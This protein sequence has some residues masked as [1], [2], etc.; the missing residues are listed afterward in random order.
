VP[1]DAPSE[2]IGPRADA[3]AQDAG[4]SLLDCAPEGRGTL[5]VGLQLAPNVDASDLWI[6]ALCGR[7][8]NAGPSDEMPMRVVRVPRLSA[9]VEL[10][11][12]GEGYYR[13]IASALGTPASSSSVVPLRGSGTAGT[14]VSIATTTVPMLSVQS[15]PVPPSDAGVHAGR[16]AGSSTQDGGGTQQSFAEFD[17]APAGSGSLGRIAVQLRPRD[18]EWVDASFV[19][20]NGCATGLC[21][22]LRV[23]G[24]ELRIEQDGLPKALVAV[25]LQGSGRGTTVGVNETFSTESRL[26][27]TSVLGAGGR[28]RLTVF[29]ALE[30]S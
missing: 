28:L 30:P 7:T 29:G 14:F 24:V 2:V 9:S 19:L 8:A 15:A 18:A 25:P 1:S 20:A 16:D 17:V 26:I 27:P 11:N 22:A 23:Q 21:P 12:L 13:V 3:A 10:Q 5:R 4:A 6:V